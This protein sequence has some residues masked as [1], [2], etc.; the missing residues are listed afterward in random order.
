MVL[1]LL[2]LLRVALGIT[3]ALSRLIAAEEVLKGSSSSP[4]ESLISVF[5]GR[6]PRRELD[7]DAVLL[8]DGLGVAKDARGCQRQTR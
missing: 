4:S 6:P 3:T 8:R 1:V 5:R 7:L 2:L